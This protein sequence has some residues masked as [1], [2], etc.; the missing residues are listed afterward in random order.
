MIFQRKKQINKKLQI[1]Q[2]FQ[3]KLGKKETIEGVHKI[4]HAKFPH[5]LVACVNF[6]VDGVFD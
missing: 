5:Q 2:P 3:T 1:Y 6:V 4:I